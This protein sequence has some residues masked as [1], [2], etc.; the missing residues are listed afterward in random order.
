MRITVEIQ[1]KDGNVGSTKWLYHALTTGEVKISEALDK[2]GM[3]QLL[4]SFQDDQIFLTHWVPGGYGLEGG[5]EA[6]SWQCA[7]DHPFTQHA[8]D[9]INSAICHWLELIENDRKN[10]PLMTIEISLIG[11]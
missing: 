1:R 8:V 2:R 3:R 7:C 11:G 9:A 5:Y 10:D 4:L 6:V